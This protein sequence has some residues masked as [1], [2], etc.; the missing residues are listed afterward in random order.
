[1]EI[2]RE[3]AGIY[4]EDTK[5]VYFFSDKLLLLKVMEY[6]FKKDVWELTSEVSYDYTYYK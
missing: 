5:E 2:Y 6:A 3:K 4:G 1:M